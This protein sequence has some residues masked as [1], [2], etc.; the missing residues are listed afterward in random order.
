MLVPGQF[1]GVPDHPTGGG[2]QRL[3]TSTTARVLYAP[4]AGP[5]ASDVQTPRI[6]RSEA[7]STTSD[8]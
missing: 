1:I 8:G 5:G 2:T 6:V 7:V 3:F 4:T